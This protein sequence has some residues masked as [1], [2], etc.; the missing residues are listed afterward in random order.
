MWLADMAGSQHYDSCTGLTGGRL[1]K[2]GALDSMDHMFPIRLA[3]IVCVSLLSKLAACECSGS[4]LN[5]GDQKTIA[6]CKSAAYSTVAVFS[7][8]GLLAPKTLQLNGM[9]EMNAGAT[10]PGMGHERAQEPGHDPRQG[11]GHLGQSL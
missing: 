2:S 6:V 3:W 4:W 5:A 8:A 10:G 1:W 11:G 9:D 7:S